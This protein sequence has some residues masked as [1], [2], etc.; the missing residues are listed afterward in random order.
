MAYFWPSTCPSL[1]W[2]LIKNNFYRRQIDKV[3]SYC[4]Q[5]QIGRP[6]ANIMLLAISTIVWFFPF[7]YTISFWCLWCCKLAAN[8]MFLTKKHYNQLRQIHLLY[9]FVMSLSETTLSFYICFELLELVKSFRLVFQE[10]NPS[11]YH[12]TALRQSKS[13]QL[14][15]MTLHSA[16]SVSPPHVSISNAPTTRL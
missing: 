14:H 13:Q 9:L 11:P 12:S 6:F 7:S 2:C 4:N 5:K 1:K 10:V 8:S 16:F 15:S 3:Y